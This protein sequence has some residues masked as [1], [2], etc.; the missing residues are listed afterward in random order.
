VHRPSY[1]P[2]LHKAPPSGELGLKGLQFL[3]RGHCTCII[4]LCFADYVHNPSELGRNFS[5]L[6]HYADGLER[7]MIISLPKYS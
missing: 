6:P 5:E 3:C 2:L 7:S 4:L 1:I